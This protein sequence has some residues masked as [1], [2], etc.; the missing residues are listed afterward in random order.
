MSASG[1]YQAAVRSST[2]LYISSDYG[3]NWIESIILTN[4]Q[5]LAMSSSGQYIST[6]GRPSKI[7]LS[8]NSFITRAVVN[9]G[10]YNSGSGVTG[11]A[12]SLYYNT[13]IG[14]ASGLQISSGSTWQNVKSFVIDHPKETSKYLVHGCME[15]PEAGIYYRGIGEITNNESTQIELPDYVENIATNMT[16]QI[17]A[18]YENRCMKMYNS[19]DIDN[20]VFHVYGP[21]GKFYWIVYGSRQDIEVEPLKTNK[22]INGDGPYKY[23]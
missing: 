15:G 22:T 20:N 5:G 1:Q 16:I 7:Y 12:G 19:T 8:N 14:G 4:A 13:T 3:K 17:T 21:N 10:S 6:A 23:I 9:V 11:C 18:I 2:S